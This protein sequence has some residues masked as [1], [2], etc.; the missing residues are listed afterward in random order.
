M[1]ASGLDLALATVIGGRAINFNHMR[2]QNRRMK[3]HP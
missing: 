3:E 2:W 1:T